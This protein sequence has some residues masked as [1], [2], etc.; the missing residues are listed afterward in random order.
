MAHTYLIQ[1]I[2]CGGCAATIRQRLGEAGIVVLEV[3]PEAQAV[4][5]AS[6]DPLHIRAGA[7][8]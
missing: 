1:N 8:I 6:D 2:R 4:R 5:M 3:S 7:A